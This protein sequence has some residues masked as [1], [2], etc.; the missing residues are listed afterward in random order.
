MKMKAD[1]SIDKYKARLVIEG[2]RQKE[3]VYYFDTYSPVTRITTIRLV[4]AIAALRNLEVHQMDVKTAFLN[5][6][7]EEEIYME[8]PKGFSAPGQEGKMC[9]LVKSLY[10]LKQAP[11]QWHHKFDQVMLNNGFKI[12]ECDK[13]VY[14][15]NTMRARFDMKDMGLAD[16]ILGIKI[17]R[18]Q[19]G[20]MLSKSH[21]VDK[22]L[23]NFNEGDTSVAQTPVDT[24]QH[25]SKNRGERVVQLEYSRI[26][27]SLMYLMTCTRPDL[28]YVVSRLSRYTSNPSS[29]HWKSMT[30]LLRYLGYTRNYGLHYGRDPAVIEGYNDANWISDMKDSKSTSG[31]VFTL[32]GAAIA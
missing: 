5:G 32:G 2:F 11:K 12:N 29:E 20:L 24:T 10:G 22:I 8:Q 23:E 4:L 19:H 27:G 14:V 15:K 18:T 31:Y 3:G 6:D 21:Y 26:I 16:V 1:G 13:C 25:L 28:A 17:N 7:L 30:R 9:K